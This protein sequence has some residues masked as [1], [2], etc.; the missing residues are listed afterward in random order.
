MQLHP[1]PHERRNTCSL[2]LIADVDNRVRD[3]EGA[4]ALVE[5]CHLAELDKVAHTNGRRQ[6]HFLLNL[7]RPGHVRVAADQL[8]CDRGE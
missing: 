7:I 8:A 2:H 3:H 1:P 5:E 6:E 4:G